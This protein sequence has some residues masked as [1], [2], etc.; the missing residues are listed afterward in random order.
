MRRAQA[1]IEF[2]MTYGWALI[3]ALAAIGALAYFGVF[4]LSN[5]IPEKCLFSQGLDC[6]QFTVINAGAKD[7]VMLYLKNNLG[8]GI[9]VYTFNVTGEGQKTS[10]TPTPTEMAIENQTAFQCQFNAFNKKQIK[11]QGSIVYSKVTGDY[12]HTTTGEIN[13]KTQ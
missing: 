12:N 10:C 2:L 3:A 1:A 11:L 6:T 7:N 9:T 13:I 4:S 8:E 5:T